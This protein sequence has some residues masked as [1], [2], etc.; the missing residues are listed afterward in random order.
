MFRLGINSNK[1]KIIRL[2]V[3]VNNL[4]MWKSLETVSIDAEKLL[5]SD[6]YQSSCKISAVFGSWQPFWNS[7]HY[8]P[9]QKWHPIFLLCLYHILTESG[10]FL[11]LPK[12]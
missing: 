2:I 7:R 9:K 12:K 1:Y 8:N 6:L 11:L 3:T 4:S 10:E 5:E